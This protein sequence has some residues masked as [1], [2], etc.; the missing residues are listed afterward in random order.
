MIGSFYESF[1]KEKDAHRDIPEE[2]LKLL[3]R[4]LPDNFCYIRRQDGTYMA[5]P[6]PDK[7]SDSLNGTFQFDFDEKTDATLIEKLSLISPLNW[8]EYFYRIQKPIPVKSIKIGNKER[9]IPIEE[10]LRDPLSE[11]TATVTDAYMYP[12]AF[13]EPVTM[14]FE[15]LENDKA[16]I[17]FQRQAYDNLAEIKFMNTDFPAL[18]IEF[19]YF[20]PLTDNLQ[21]ETAVTSCEAPIK[22]R[23]SVTPS[24]APTV[25][26][27]ITALHICKGL[28]DGTLKINGQ[29]LSLPNEESVIIST[30]IDEALTFWATALQL[31]EILGVS[32]DPNAEFPEEDVRFF[33]ELESCLIKEKAIVWNHPFD[34]FHLG[35]FHPVSEDK[36]LENLIGKSTI[37]YEFIEGP[38]PATLLGAEFNIYSRT[39][40]MDLVMTNI[41]WD[42]ESKSGG[43][44]YIAD[45]PDKVWT[46]SRLYLPKS[47]IEAKTL[48]S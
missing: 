27:A 35:S 24:K 2:V 15:T 28:C 1:S 37:H 33:A 16:C 3:N 21:H 31:E 40:M 5:C 10:T 23:Y 25:K 41:A 20:S 46:L 48:T 29:T 38:I 8:A 32:F 42:D 44:V 30:Q 14:F 45:A 47:K 26:S 36:K 39:K 22:V 17:N 7:I 9:V 19:Y 6:N 18:K 43:E 4:D 13:P 34:H 12:T 11:N